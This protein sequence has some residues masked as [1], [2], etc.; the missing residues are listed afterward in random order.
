MSDLWKKFYDWL[1]AG[2]W[3]IDTRGLPK[4][5]RLGIYSVRMAYVVVRELVQG[6]LAL[7]A[8]SLVYTTLL[9]LVPLLAVSFSVLKAF[10]VHNQ[11]E[12]LLYNFLTP[13]GPKG[14]DLAAR[15]VE[16]VENVKVGVLGSLGLAM[17]IYTV[18]SLMEKIERSFNWVWRIER[19][20]GLGQRFSSYLTVI[21]IGPVLVFT[22]LGITASVMSHSLVQ[23]MVAIEPVGTVFLWAG[24][25]VP[26]VLVW[27]A[28][29]FLY[30]FMP[31]TR[32]K[33]AAAALGGLFAAVLWQT[34]GWLFAAFI[35][36]SA[37]YAAIYSSFAILVVLLIWL[38]LSWLILL[39][40]AQ[41]T[42]Y[43]Q[44]PQ[45]LSAQRVK[46]VL[47]NRL[48]ERLALTVMFLIGYSHYHDRQPW[49]LDGLA[50]HLA[51]PA[52]A[53]E[54]VLGI[55]ESCH[56]VVTTSDE[57]PAYLP[58]RDIETIQL[59]ELY[60][61]VRRAEESRLLNYQRVPRLPPVEAVVE[62]LDGA[63]GAALDE[64]NLKSL[65]VAY[66]GQI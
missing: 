33:V 1:T 5:R 47:S 58:A 51:V 65:V 54:R 64:E 56:Y 49:T 62:R 18:V 14:A 19:M 2:L 4:W 35:A 26:Y 30:H 43:V 41:V 28:F 60:G 10:G 23:Q 12:P 40:G 32:V 17:L 39:L 34:T 38:Y 63:A 42:F 25:L 59:T 7:R 13:L 8:M 16:F 66:R 6:D 11:I 37:R 15:I 24:K 9:S 29:T 48:R 55:L 57:P 22:A 21:M 61:A 45:Y 36:S 53:M 52:E 44:Q 50:E 46:V 27:A 31:N 20:R 3:D